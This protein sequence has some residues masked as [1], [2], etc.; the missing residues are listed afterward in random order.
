M[1]HSIFLLIVLMITFCSCGGCTSKKEN[2]QL[3]CDTTML[4]VPNL[5]SGE[6]LLKYSDFIKVGQTFTFKDINYVDKLSMPLQIQKVT[7]K[8]TFNNDN[9][10]T[11]QDNIGN[12]HTSKAQSA[13]AQRGWYGD[14]PSSFSKEYEQSGS[15]EVCFGLG[16]ETLTMYHQ[17]LYSNYGR[18]E[19][20]VKYNGDTFLYL[21][22][23]NIDYIYPYEY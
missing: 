14:V 2:G 3:F 11:L 21:S 17:L 12:T 4:K 23:P 9:T 8:V 19:Y 5:Y 15:V 7:L 16:D 10:I 1:R 18:N 22:G 20:G 13:Y 6:I